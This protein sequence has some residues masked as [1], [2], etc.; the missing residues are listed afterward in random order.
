VAATAL[1]LRNGVGWGSATRRRRV[2]APLMGDAA[3]RDGGG[4][5]DGGGGRCSYAGYWGWLKSCMLLRS[6]LAVEKRQQAPCKKKKHRENA[7]ELLVH[8]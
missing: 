7:P 6:Y 3:R 1:L 5:G 8:L 4:S 2:Q